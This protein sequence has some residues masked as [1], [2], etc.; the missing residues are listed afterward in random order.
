VSRIGERQNMD[1]LAGPQAKQ[2]RSAAAK[3]RG[4]NS[5]TN[6]EY[7]EARRAIAYIGSGSVAIASSKPFHKIG[8]LS[9]VTHGKK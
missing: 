3:R 2:E 7:A 5:P 9:E 1:V 4:P 6:G 8:I